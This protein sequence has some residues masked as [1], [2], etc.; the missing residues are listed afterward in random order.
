MSQKSSFLQLS[1]SVSQALTPDNLR[2]IG[3]AKGDY[4]FVLDNCGDNG[5]E[6]VEYGLFKDPDDAMMFKLRH[7]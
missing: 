6:P 7:G 2:E 4:T 3:I 1:Q 5:C